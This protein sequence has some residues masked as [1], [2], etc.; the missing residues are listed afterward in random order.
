MN[1]SQQT[2]LLLTA[3]KPGDVSFYVYLYIDDMIWIVSSI[4]KYDNTN[5]PLLFKFI[6]IYVILYL[7]AIW[8]KS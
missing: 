4:D 8:S 3:Q 7:F 5:E 6:T 2:N 1:K